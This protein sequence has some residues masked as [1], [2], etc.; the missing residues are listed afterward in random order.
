MSEA[1]PE[2]DQN[3][4]PII[5]EYAG[6]A[7]PIVVIVLWPSTQYTTA[8]AAHIPLRSSRAA[9]TAPSASRHTR[10]HAPAC[11]KPAKKSSR[12]LHDLPVNHQA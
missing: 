4:W 6:F 1:P 3:A 11:T 7:V 10:R 8:L 12:G 5:A 2:S 9:R